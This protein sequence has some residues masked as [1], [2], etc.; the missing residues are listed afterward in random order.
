M[1][2]KSLPPFLVLPCE[3]QKNSATPTVHQIFELM[4][5]SKIEN[6]G[7][8]SGSAIWTIEETEQELAYRA[9]EQCPAEII[10]PQKRLEWL[11]GRVL[12]RSLLEHH[13]LSYSGVHKDE[14]GKPFLRDLAHPISLSHSFPFVAAQFDKTK[15]VGIDLEQPKE[16]LLRIAP[17]V[18]SASEQKNAGN[19]VIKHCVY[20][21]A[22]EALYKIHGKRALHFV[23]QL[24][25]EPFELSQNG[26]LKGTITV[27]EHKQSVDLVYQISEYYVLVLTKT[28]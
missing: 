2:L 13:G 19:N 27:N 15:Q 6:S 16:K 8:H 17:R 24:N 4:P 14:F 21:C 7:M 12:L 3:L 26:N 1:T 28:N 22:K 20:W 23:D 5:L 18:L 11:A 25:I 10:H 9:F